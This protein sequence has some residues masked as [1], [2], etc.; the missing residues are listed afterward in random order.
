MIN[1]FHHDQKAGFISTLFL[2]LQYQRCCWM[3]LIYIYIHISYSYQIWCFSWC[4]HHG[5]AMVLNAP[6][7]MISGAQEAQKAQPM[8][9]G[10]RK[11]S[12]GRCEDLGEKDGKTMVKIWVNHEKINMGKCWENDDIMGYRF[13][14][15]HG[16]MMGK[17]TSKNTTDTMW[18]KWHDFLWTCIE[19][20]EKGEIVMALK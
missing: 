6:W 2:A 13:Q 12:A 7:P 18:R 3:A 9:R 11:Q 8:A 15:K 19:W 17:R 16:K 14:N 4:F 20:W 5:P 1:G 10:K